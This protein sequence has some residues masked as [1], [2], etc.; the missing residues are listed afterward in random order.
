[1]WKAA[2]ARNASFSSLQKRQETASS[3]SFSSVTIMTSTPSSSTSIQVTTLL[4][5]PNAF[6]TTASTVTTTAPVVGATNPNAF[7][8]T[9]QT[10][11]TTFVPITTTAAFVDTIRT[12]TSTP[13]VAATTNQDAFVATKSTTSVTEAPT[14]GATN[15]NAFVPTI[16]S[17]G[18]TV[19]YSTNPNAFVATASTSVSTVPQAYVPTIT[20]IAVAVSYSTSSNGVV[21]T[22]SSS[23]TTTFLA[24]SS[25]IDHTSIKTYMTTE[26]GTSTSAIATTDANGKSTT[27][28]S[29][30]PYTTVRQT[31]SAV[32]TPKAIENNNPRV[33]EIIQTWPAWKIF[34]GGY[35][36]VFLAV[37]F[38]LFWTAI[39][40]KIKL[41]EPFT[42]MA[43][44]EGSVASETLHTYYLSSYLMPDAIFSMMK[45]HWLIF[46]SAVVYLAVGLLAPLSS[47]VLFADSN[48]NCPNPDFSEDKKLI[49]CFPP[50]LSVDPVMVRL[51]QGLLAFIAVMTINLM[52]MMM[53]TATGLYSD[54]SSIG[55]I[56]ALTHHPDVLDDFRKLDDEVLLQDVRKKLGTRR[57]KLDNYQRSDGIW[58]YGFVPF[59]PANTISYDWNDENGP[60]PE[61]IKRAKTF[62]EG[63][64]Q[65]A[66][67]DAV[68]DC[69]F[70]LLLLATMGILIAFFKDSG[71]NAFNRF[72]NSNT[73]G[74]RF[75][76][77]SSSSP[78]ISYIDLTNIPI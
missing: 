10:K 29:A 73:F 70:L 51:L 65:Q 64:R 31:S 43:R 67:W 37:L 74:P 75:V 53:R 4:T 71:D 30:V 59:S 23:Y 60:G 58:R 62:S 77:A 66:I 9:V 16:T 46:W 22:I 63:S 35:C 19:S 26:L 11:T 36:P 6:V 8:D 69:S 18:V 12:T 48:W 20:S 1:M 78:L 15:P 57:Y 41:I 50:K 24:S 34:V 72:F 2:Q 40:A 39:Y 13:K 56:A 32:V 21:Q 33:L 27:V 47:E 25:Y 14:V 5:N 3:T 68:F 61:K 49:P 17:I 38:K 28:F 55:A 42:R 44:P 76:M 45:G 52:I 7:V 54:P